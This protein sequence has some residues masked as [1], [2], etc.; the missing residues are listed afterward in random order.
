M[1]KWE[2]ERLEKQKLKAEKEKEKAEREKS[3]KVL[4]RFPFVSVSLSAVNLAGELSFTIRA[5]CGAVVVLFLFM[6]SCHIKDP[7]HQNTKEDKT[8]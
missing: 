1:K 7:A 6:F 8:L 2:R 4:P 3:E 5:L